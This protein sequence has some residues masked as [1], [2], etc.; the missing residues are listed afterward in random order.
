MGVFFVAIKCCKFS[1]LTWGASK[2]VFCKG[3]GSASVGNGRFIEISKNSF[4]IHTPI[5]LKVK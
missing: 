5:L 2:Y 4:G 3:L 1:E